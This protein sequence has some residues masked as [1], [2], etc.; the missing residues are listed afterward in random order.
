LE[1]FAQSKPHQISGGQQQRVA[2]ARA[3]VNKPR[4]LLL[5]ESL[6]ALD[7]KLRKQSQ[8]EM[9]ALQRKLGITFVFVTPDK[10]EALT[11]PDRIV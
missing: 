4:L 8:N 3:V 1:T 6:S 5:G 10:E 2:F 11:M 9:K 7:Y